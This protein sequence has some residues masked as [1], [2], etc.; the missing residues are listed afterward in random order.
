LWIIFSAFIR[1][2]ILVATNKLLT[3]QLDFQNLSSYYIVL[4]IYN[5]FGSI[6]IGPFGEYII[7]IFFKTNSKYNIAF[8]LESFY[9][10]L[11][12]PIAL[13]SL[14]LL[15][16]GLYFYFGLTNNYFIEI[17][18]LISLML[19]FRGIFDS[20]IYFINA[21]GY[22]RGYSILITFNALVYYILSFL[23]TKILQPTYFIWIS[24]F[25]LSNIIFSTVT[26]Y[27]LRAYAIN[28][29]SKHKFYFNS[30]I[31][32]FV[33][34]LIIINILL[35]FL[36]DGFRFLSEFKFGLESSATLL[37][38]FALAS[39]L[40]SIMAN[41]ILPIFTPNLVKSYS[42]KSKNSRY[43]SFKNY[44]L[45]VAPFLILT[46]ILSLLFSETLIRILVD[47]S[48]IQDELITIFI[49][50]LFV[51]FLR[52]LISV[53]KNYKLSENRLIYQV[54]SLII[55]LILLLLTPFIP[56][57]STI[58]FALYMFLIYFIYF[59]TSVLFSIKLKNEIPKNY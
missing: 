4:S 11:F 29:N 52:S 3:K 39:Q 49:I 12:L 44:L 41:F 43:I 38:G 58:I 37:L 14:I 55:P 53:I 57:N 27:F 25:V 54:Y 5:F 6:I 42:E 56:I 13:M 31:K 19:V 24:G 33:P 50:G 8:F 32:K 20:N 23:L 17:P 35:W 36:T 51:E 2:L 10:K 1:I 47:K 46:L 40:F 45:K 22:Y 9:K 7:K 16:I 15:I 21:L 48:K 28:K 30:K 18:I 34:S 59:V 26:V